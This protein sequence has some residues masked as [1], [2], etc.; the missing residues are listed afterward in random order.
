MYLYLN[1]YD[2]FKA[3]LFSTMVYGYYTNK[4]HI[5]IVESS[6]EWLGCFY[7]LLKTEQSFRYIIH[8]A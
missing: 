3:I 1:G 8:F 7:I 6:I 2:M 4:S 5:C